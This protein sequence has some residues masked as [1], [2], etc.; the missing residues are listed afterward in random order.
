LDEVLAEARQA[1][2]AGFKELVLTGANLGCYR[3]GGCSLADLIRQVEA[4]PEVAR[5]RLSSIE[6]T[7]VEREVI[8][9]MACSAKLCR[10]LHL[11]LQ[12]GSDRIL[13]AMGRRYRRDEFRAAAEYAARVVPRIGLGTDILVGFPG[14][15]EEAFMDTVRLVEELP[16]SNL[17]VFPYSRRPGT[18]AESLPNQVPAA[19][20]KERVRRLLDIERDKRRAFAEKFIGVAVKV[21]IERIDAQG[22]GRG[23]TGEYLEACVSGPELQPNRIVEFTPVE[24]RDGAL[25]GRANAR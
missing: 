16:F 12:S 18:R 10:F 8:D 7:T 2:A 5:I 23:W 6:I 9:L 21:L 1:A 19:V 11:P 22:R 20:K 3:D 4:V 15:D 25:C 14:E 24:L 17:H 13:A